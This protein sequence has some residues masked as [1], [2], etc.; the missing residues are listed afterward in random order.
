[1]AA[2]MQMSALGPNPMLGV[3]AKMRSK[4]LKLCVRKIGFKTDREGVTLLEVL[5]V[6]GLVSLM[7]L[8][9]LPNI[10]N[11]LETRDLENQARDILTT[12]QR[13]KFQAVKSKLN[14]RV[15]FEDL[16]SYWVYYI[17]REDSPGTWNLMPGL[18]KKPV[19]TKFIITVNLPSLLATFS[20]LGFVTDFD[21]NQNS[22]T[23]QSPKLN[24]AGQPD[25]RSISVF[26]GGSVR[27]V[28]N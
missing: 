10:R 1:M 19:I 12:M 4:N 2:D 9:A 22:V 7:M 13:A 6:I 11:S 16:G 25:Q 27:Y 17:E 5:I 8:L 26:A 21:T 24:R 18:V 23:L 20:P 14:H 28:K 3:S 15:R